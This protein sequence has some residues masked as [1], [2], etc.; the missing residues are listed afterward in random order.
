MEAFYGGEGWDR[1][2]KVLGARSRDV[3]KACGLDDPEALLLPF[4]NDKL[5]NNPP[6]IPAVIEREMLSRHIAMNQPPEVQSID[7]VTANCGKVG[8]EGEREG[9]RMDGWKKGGMDSTH[10]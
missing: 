6:A 5:N 10:T 3:A 1:R 4:Q 8:K 7:Y 2:Y 9:R